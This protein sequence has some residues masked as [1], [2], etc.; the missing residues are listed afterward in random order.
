MWEQASSYDDEYNDL[1]K[2][3][4]SILKEIDYYTF[5][6]DDRGSFPKLVP[7]RVP[8]WSEYMIN[9]LYSTASTTAA[10]WNMKIVR[11]PGNGQGMSKC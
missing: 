8:I 9:M 7:L 4:E 6:L 5:L 10:Y 1:R 3:L 2:L 11:G